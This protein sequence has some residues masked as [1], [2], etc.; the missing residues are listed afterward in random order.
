MRSNERASH[1]P[2]ARRL[3]TS[4]P[5]VG[6]RNGCEATA[7]QAKCQ[8]NTAPGLL[9]PQPHGLKSFVDFCLAVSRRV[10][11]TSLPGS[12]GT[13]RGAIASL[14]S[15]RPPGCLV[16]PTDCFAGYDAA[17][18]ARRCGV[19]RSGE[20]AAGI[21]SLAPARLALTGLPAANL[22]KQLPQLRVA[23]RSRLQPSRWEEAR[24]SM[25]KA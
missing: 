3:G 4:I 13:L 8:A 12:C 17:P 5:A 22:P 21:D 23:Q 25:P 6:C 10:D 1:G 20:I 18:A 7:G 19:A 16:R 15:A 24:R 9:S 14:S 11:A 2:R